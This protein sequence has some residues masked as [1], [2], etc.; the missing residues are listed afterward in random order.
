MQSRLLNSL[1]AEARSTSNRKA[2]ARAVCRAA[3][4]YARHGDIAHAAASISA[5]RAEFGNELDPEVG[6]WLML[7]EGISHFFEVR[8]KEAY[9]RTQRAYAIARALNIQSAIPTCAAWMAHLEFN[10]G[11]Y[12]AMSEHLAEA[13]SSAASD[14]HQAG[15]RASLVMAD[16]LHFAGAFQEARPWYERCRLHATAEGDDA[17]LSAM[18][19]NVAAFRASNVRLSDAFG[20][21]DPKE[22]RRAW[23]EAQSAY[24]FDAAI[25]GEGLQ[26]LLP[27]LRGQILAVEGKYNEALDLL[28]SI[29]TNY[30]HKRLVPLLHADVGWCLA[31][32]NRLDEAWSNSVISIDL[33]SILDE[34]DD[35]AYVSARISQTAHKCNKS[36]EGAKW[37]EFSI[38]AIAA[39]KNIQAE[40]IAKLDAIGPFP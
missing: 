3:S 14:D 23:L 4:H 32:L 33:I 29:N 34:P 37:Q 2:W 24:A 9:D 26:L 31:G 5:V 22:A 40:L 1:L 7:A 20:E 15:A 6:S 11:A 25:G 35:L 21:V 36:D 30:I 13:L 27:L 8:T 16:A 38:R 10:S 18:F 17:T 19:H 12:S 39:H 28:L